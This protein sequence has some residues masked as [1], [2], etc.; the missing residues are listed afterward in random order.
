MSKEKSYRELND[1][2]DGIISRLQ[3]SDLDVDQVVKEYEKASVLVKQLEAY[4]KSASNKITK[5]N[6]GNTKANK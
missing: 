3:S 2:L 4:L 5:V 6:V 1:E